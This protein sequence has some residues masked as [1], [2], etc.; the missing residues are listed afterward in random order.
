MMMAI[1]KLA[2]CLAVMTILSGC[3]TSNDTKADQIIAGAKRVCDFAPTLT[4]IL[5]LL[6]VPGAGASDK[7]VQKICA[8]IKARRSDADFV[9]P[10]QKVK[11]EI[12]GVAVEG[13][14][15]K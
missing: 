5:A 3:V 4:S 1:K 9:E 2:A 11:I 7:I 14:L 15:L 6:E 10:G 13:T 12:D 8:E